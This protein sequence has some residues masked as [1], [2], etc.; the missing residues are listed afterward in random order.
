MI[1]SRHTLSEL[2]RIALA[3][4]L[5][6]AALLVTRTFL[7]LRAIDIGFT[8]RRCWRST[9]PQP[10]NRYPTPRQA[11]S[12]TAVTFAAFAIA[13]TGLTALGLGTL[14]SRPRRMMKVT[15]PNTF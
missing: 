10:P 13:A 5:M 12:S 6:A 3:V 8:P 2:L 15:S 9:V 4:V 14:R 11:C 1:G 7:N